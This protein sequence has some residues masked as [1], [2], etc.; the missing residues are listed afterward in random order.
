MD[1]AFATA[2]PALIVGGY[3]PLPIAPA[4][5]NAWSPKGKEPGLELR[6]G[7]NAEWIRMRS[8]QIFCARQPHAKTI[9]V[10]SKYPDA[11]VGVACG[12]GGLVAVDIDDE[13]LVEPLLAVLPRV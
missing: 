2:A 8:W 12:F 6:S 5:D 3:S 11:G 7:G 1:S 10:W 4:G 13:A 9:A